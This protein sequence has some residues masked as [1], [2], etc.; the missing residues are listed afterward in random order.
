MEEGLA[1]KAAAVQQADLEIGAGKTIASFQ[2]GI[3]LF[4][5]FLAFGGSGDSRLR[6]RGLGGLAKV[7]RRLPDGVFTEG[8]QVP[9]MLP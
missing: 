4:G 8:P 7:L 3:C 1:L 6:L 9:Y 5:G 2:T